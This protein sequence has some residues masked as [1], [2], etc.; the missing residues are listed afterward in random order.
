MRAVNITPT[1]VQD[2]LAEVNHRYRGNIRFKREPEYQGN[3]TR[4]TLTVCDSTGPGSRISPHR[5]TV[6]G[7]PRRIHAACWHAHGHFFE[8]LFRLPSIDPKARLWAGSTLITGPELQDG[9]WQ[10]RDIGT[11]MYSEACDCA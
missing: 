6:S 10:D 5:Q 8:A 4:F 7:N 3:T 9:N 1:Q 2:A 11:C